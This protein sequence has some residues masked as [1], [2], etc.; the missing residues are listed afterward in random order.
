VARLNGGVAQH[1]ANNS[2]RLQTDG[3]R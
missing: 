1:P 2:E 3:I